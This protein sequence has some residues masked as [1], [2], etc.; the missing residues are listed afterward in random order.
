MHI[1]QSQEQGVI[2]DAVMQ[3]RLV[4]LSILT[5]AYLFVP[6]ESKWHDLSPD[7]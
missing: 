3:P 5:Q 1:T 2:A 4:E 6:N 7:S